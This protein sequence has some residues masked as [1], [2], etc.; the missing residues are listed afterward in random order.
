MGV[1][2]RVSGVQEVRQQRDPETPALWAASSSAG[3]AAR[4]APRGADCPVSGPD[5]SPPTSVGSG[6]PWRK[7]FCSSEPSGRLPAGKCAAWSPLLRVCPLG[8]VSSAVSSVLSPKRGPTS[9]KVC[10]A[11]S[12]PAPPLPSLVLHQVHCSSCCL[13]LHFFQEALPDHP[14]LSHIPLCPAL[15]TNEDTVL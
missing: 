5:P 8:S 2:S 11:V 10:A 9:S 4:A 13:M 6:P 3:H 1:V 15:G 7:G 14:P 12:D